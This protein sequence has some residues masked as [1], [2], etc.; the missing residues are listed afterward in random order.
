MEFGGLL[1]CFWDCVGK[2]S[3]NFKDS[4]LLF[5]LVCVF[6]SKWSAS[7][8]VFHLEIK[9]VRVILQGGHYSTEG[10]NINQTDRQASMNT[11]I[12]S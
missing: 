1:G 11:A 2:G 12:P 8:S 5:Q 4:S 7:L 9:V 10:I 6:F 3:V